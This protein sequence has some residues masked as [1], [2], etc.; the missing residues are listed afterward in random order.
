[1]RV[2]LLKMSSN[3]YPLKNTNSQYLLLNTTIMPLCKSKISLIFLW[4]YFSFCV[5]FFFFPFALATNW[6]I[7]NLLKMKKKK[8]TT[9]RYHHFTQVHQKLWLDDVQFL[10]QG[11]Q[12]TDKQTDGQTDRQK[13]WHIE[14]GAPPKNSD[15]EI[16]NKLAEYKKRYYEMW[17]KI[18]IN[19]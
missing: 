5:F 17:K 12:W 18:V 6:K 7:K 9:W 8:K 13:K 11:V 10:R 1:M 4:G 19:I 3:V 15:T 14:V 16:K 2:V